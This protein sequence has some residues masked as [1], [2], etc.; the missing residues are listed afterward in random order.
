MSKSRCHA[1]SADRSAI[2]VFWQP[3]QALGVA[4]AARIGNLLGAGEP[5]LARRATR[6]SLLVVAPLSAFG[7]SLATQLGRDVWPRLFSTD[8]KIIALARTQVRS[9]P[10]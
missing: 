3:F 5:Q 10:S 9:R 8:E 2:T 1:R 6:A 4:S 7:L